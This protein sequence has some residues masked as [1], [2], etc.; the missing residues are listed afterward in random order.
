V[1]VVITYIVDAFVHVTPLVIVLVVC[2]VGHNSG[3]ASS[4]MQSVF[5]RIVTLSSC[6]A[7]V[8]SML[9]LALCTAVPVDTLAYDV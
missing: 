7:F 8:L 5:V 1:H 3:A 9:V 6:D 2:I 4:C